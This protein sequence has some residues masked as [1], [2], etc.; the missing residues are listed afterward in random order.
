MCV[1][2]RFIHLVSP[3][4]VIMPDNFIFLFL[5]SLRGIAAPG[6]LLGLTKLP[7]C[8]SAAFRAKPNQL[9]IAPS[10]ENQAVD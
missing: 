9:N 1:T 3:V 7:D 2:Q 4:S 5:A 6:W 8:F 10:A